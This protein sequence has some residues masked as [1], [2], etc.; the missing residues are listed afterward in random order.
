MGAAVEDP[1]RQQGESAD[2]HRESQSGGAL[3]GATEA[4]VENDVCAPEAAREQGQRYA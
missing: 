1:D 3:E 4:R 2:A